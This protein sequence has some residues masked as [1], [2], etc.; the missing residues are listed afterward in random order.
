MISDLF[1]KQ[2]RKYDEEEVYNVIWSTL[3][4]WFAFTLSVIFL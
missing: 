1:E 2:K 3:F 4:M